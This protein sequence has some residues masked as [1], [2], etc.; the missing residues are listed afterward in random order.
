MEMSYKPNI[1]TYEDYYQNPTL[2]YDYDPE[3]S[4]IIEDPYTLPE[5]ATTALVGLFPCSRIKF[6]RTETGKMITKYYDHKIKQQFLRKGQ[7]PSEW[8]P[9]NGEL[10][11]IKLD[12]ELIIVDP[13]RRPSM[14][15]RQAERMFTEMCRR[16]DLKMPPNPDI[17]IMMHLHQ[18]F[19]RAIAIF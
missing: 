17:D 5:G 14:V 11:Y 3:G 13:D 10:D 8:T 16:R 18:G 1:I 12:R 4:G 15:L 2:D 7:W 6:T 9:D 19:Y